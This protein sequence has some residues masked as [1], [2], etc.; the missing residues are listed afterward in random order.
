MLFHVTKKENIE[1]ILQEGIVAQIGMNSQNVMETENMVYLCDE[2]SVPY[3]S[4]ILGADAVFKV[5][6]IKS[7]SCVR[8]DYGPY[9]EYAYPYDI[10][11]EHI[12]VFSDAIPGREAA[13]KDLCLSYI[14]TVSAIAVHTARFYDNPDL[15]NGQTY[16]ADISRQILK[17][18]LYSTTAVLERLDFSVC[19]VEDMRSRIIDRGE[20]GHYVFTDYYKSTDNRLWEMFDLYPDDELKEGR[21]AFK[22][23]I[24][25]GFKD[26]LY[27]NTGGWLES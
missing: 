7:E 19:P 9:I 16:K 18:E 26:C 22:N 27:E 21:K 3:W 2:T 8:Y 5:S 11:P 13:M 4:I 6:G 17:S 20:N 12:E 25:K 14:N 1:S 15:W 10:A 23:A 24:C